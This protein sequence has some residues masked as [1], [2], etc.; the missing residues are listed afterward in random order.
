MHLTK[1]WHCQ[2]AKPGGRLAYDGRGDHGSARRLSARWNHAG[3]VVV[4]TSTTLSLAALET[5]VH[6][7]LRTEPNDLV[8]ITADVPVNEKLFERERAR[9]L[10]QVPAELRGFDERMT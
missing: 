1:D 2:M 5:L 3:V 9:V 8:Y 4:Y 10:S 6:A 7:G